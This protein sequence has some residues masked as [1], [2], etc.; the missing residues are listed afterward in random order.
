[1]GRQ[2]TRNFDK[3]LKQ[4][5]DFINERY[6]LNISDSD[7]SDHYVDLRTLYYKMSLDYTSATTKDIGAMA[8]RD[9]S[10]VVYARNNLFEYIMTKP[11]LS[12]AY[13]DFFGI[14]NEVKSKMTNLANLRE[15][16]ERERMESINNAGLTNNEVMYRRLSDDQK[17]AYDERASLFLKSLDWKEYNTTF[18]TINVGY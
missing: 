5:Y 6:R 3:E 13:N 2:K 18:E 17:R 4:I 1:M 14:E 8:N 10:T 9:H 15:K 12:E 7:R 16:A 11:H